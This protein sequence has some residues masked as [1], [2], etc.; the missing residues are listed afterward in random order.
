[1][2]IVILI[3]LFIAALSATSCRPVS[4]TVANPLDSSAPARQV[5]TPTATSTP[6]PTPTPASVDEQQVAFGRAT[7]LKYY[8]GVCH[9]LPAAGTAGVFGPS[10]EH[11]GSLAGARVTDPAYTGSATTP[12]EYVRESIVE[13]GVY[14][15]PGGA[16]SR[17]AMPPFGHL[18]AEEID[19]LVYFLLQQQ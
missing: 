6:V 14:I 5:A 3:C 17:M 4:R 11:I 8:C 7:Y 13:P 9:A 1:M 15:A 19:A 12:A 10:H 16:N 18:P 2:R